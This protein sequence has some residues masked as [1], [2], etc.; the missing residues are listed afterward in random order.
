MIRRKLNGAGQSRTI[1]GKLANNARGERAWNLS[2]KSQYVT[3]KN[4]RYDKM[5]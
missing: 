1:K 4:K 3:Y 5:E 2:E